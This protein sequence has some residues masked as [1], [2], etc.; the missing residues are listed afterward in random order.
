MNHRIT[1]PLCTAALVLAA[2]LVTGCGAGDDDR[3]AV[4]TF[5]ER[6]AARGP[7]QRIASV[8]P[9][10]DAESLLDWAQW[11]YPTLF[12]KGAT[13][14]DITYL[15]VAYA[16][17]AYP[18]DTYLGV[19]RQGEVWGLGPF[20]GNE[21]KSFG[22][23][24]LY[25][26]QVQADHCKVYAERCTV[27][28]SALDAALRPLIASHGLTGDPTVGRELPNIADA[29]PQLG[30]LLFFSKSLS[31][32]RDTACASCHHPALGGTDQ[33]GISIG[34]GAQR[35]DLVGPGRQ[36][37]DGQLLVARNANTF[38]N[39]GLYDRAL[40]AD[41]RIESLIAA[42]A[43][44]SPNGQGT[45]IRTPASTG[46]A[47]DP[48]AGPNLP[49]A[50]AR[51]PIAGVAEMRGDALPGL[52]D[53]QLREH[54]ASRLAGEAATRL[55][56]Q[57]WLARFRLAFNR[58]TGT[59]AELITFDNIMVAI[60]EY[61][62][63]AVF[64]KS[65]WQRY[66]LG[67]NSAISDVAKRGA[68]VFYQPVASGGAQCVQCHK[69]DFFTDE[70]FHV[71]G[72]PQAGPGFA[73]DHG[74]SGRERI[75]GAAADRMA[76]R[77]PSLLNVDMTGP[78]GHAGVY[79][80]LFKVFR[81]YAVPETAV[82]AFLTGREWCQIPGYAQQPGCRDAFADVS[83]L[84][85]LGLDQVYAQRFIDSFNTLIPLDSGKIGPT[86]NDQVVAFLRTLT[87]PCLRDRACLARWIPR[88]DEAPDA[89]QL[90]AV[91]ATG[92]PL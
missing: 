63:S 51:F 38:F 48:L 44:P 3:A 56:G 41:G 74:D 11:Q 85:L 76:F 62:R 15:G 88:P 37:A 22:A 34:A 33:L 18:G 5:V 79:D 58:P 65:A 54:I 25:A 42:A 71:I 12:P 16:V 30:K 43:N 57:G 53:D 40:F 32:Q 20:T 92:A 24:A 68:L 29:M 81:H 80:T 1:A 45:P 28:A 60:A 73:A 86:Q 78:W 52:T 8:A 70:K 77:T 7:T 49:A 87:D 55:D 17:R 61:E 13:T 14:I 66:V 46:G 59:A 84:T 50:Q 64:V 83:R 67:E 91:D 47:A 89:F 21:L 69:G 23:V 31:A 39:I 2:V 10:V 9:G 4:Q 27:A 6:V 82:D 72:F 90:N 75:N 36:R 35:P 26:A 19:S